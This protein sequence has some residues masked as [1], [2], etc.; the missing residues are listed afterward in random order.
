MAE[1]LKA[2]TRLRDEASGVEAIVVKVPTGSDLEIVP[3]DAVSLGK[4]YTCGTCQSQVIVAKA[5]PAQ[6]NCHGAPMGLVE[7]KA[8]PSSD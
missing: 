4:R 5:G 2:G 7:A 6:V 3:G 1:A 8:L